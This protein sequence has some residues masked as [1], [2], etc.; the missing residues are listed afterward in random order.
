MIALGKD[1]S[2]LAQVREEVP[3]GSTATPCSKD[4]F[5]LSC[6]S[7]QH[8]HDQLN[9]RVAGAVRNGLAFLQPWLVQACH[10]LAEVKQWLS[11]DT[12][13]LRLY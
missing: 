8:S 6:G 12:C 2:A 1:V 5:K 10:G 4:N 7:L 9:G 3:F 13:G 11:A